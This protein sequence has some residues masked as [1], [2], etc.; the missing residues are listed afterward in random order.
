MHLAGTTP[1]G[2]RGK[3]PC[4]NGSRA[5]AHLGQPSRIRVSE[6]CADPG[7][8]VGPIFARNCS[9]GDVFILLQLACVLL[10]GPCPRP[11]IWK[12]IFTFWRH[13]DSWNPYGRRR[14][15]SGFLISNIDFKHRPPCKLNSGAIRNASP[16]V[17]R[18]A[19]ES[20]M[21]VYM[22]MA[23]RTYKTRPPICTNTQTR[24]PYASNL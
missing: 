19:F 18:R 2:S 8:D 15:D 20:F 21:Q 9:Y 13:S 11:V 1:F 22:S 24:R 6:M 14:S 4:A 16:S 17:R 12:R 3:P 10:A 7:L 23:A 5:D